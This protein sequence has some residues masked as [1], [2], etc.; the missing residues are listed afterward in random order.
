[1]KTVASTGPAWM[2][3]VPNILTVFRLVL[4][5]VLIWLMLAYP[6]W[7][8]R[9]MWAAFFVFFVA[10]IT[11][12]FDGDIARKY[13]IITNFG[14]IADPIADKA[15]V[16]PALAI[17]VWNLRNMV[18]TWLFVLEAICVLLIVVREIGISIWRMEMVRRG[19]VIPASRGGKIKTVAQMGFIGFSLIPWNTFAPNWVVTIVIFV[20]AIGLGLATYLA[21]ISARDYLR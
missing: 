1:M 4:V 12:K 6:S 11:D 13:N 14:K 21:L 16:L 5:P 8:D 3:P 15:L 10:S 9:G 18:P 17:V 2:R 20:C 19:K 7:H